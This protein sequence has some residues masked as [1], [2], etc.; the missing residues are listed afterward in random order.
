MLSPQDSRRL[1][2]IP[3]TRM[4]EDALGFSGMHVQ[5]PLE[6]W[7]PWTIQWLL[8]PIPGR[9]LGG[10]RAKLVDQ[11][12]FISFC[13]QR[14]LEVMIGHGKPGT[15]CHWTGRD[16]PTPG[17]SDWYGLCCDDEDLRDDLFER[18]CRLREEYVGHHYL[19]TGLEIRRR[20]HIDQGVDTEELH[21]LLWDMDVNT[22]QYPD[23]RLETV[24]R[25]W[26]RVER[27]LLQWDRI[28]P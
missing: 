24:Q 28:R 20:L 19:P 26:S 15:Y 8:A 12:G 7:R 25:R 11:K 14:D 17:E 16:Y 6:P 21:T 23:P 27:S 3:G 18:E 4:L 5:D 22:R 2:V 9:H 10:F 1:P 13:N